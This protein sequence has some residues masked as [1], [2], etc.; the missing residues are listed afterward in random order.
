MLTILLIED[1]EGDAF[2]LRRAFD[3]EGIL[4]SIQVATDGK[5]GMRYLQ[6]EGEFHD[7][8][9][10]PFPDFVFTDLNMPV[11]NGFDLLEWR[12]T[13]ND[14]SVVP[15]MV[16]SASNHQQDIEKS[17][18]LGTNAYFVKPSSLSQLQK[19]LRDTHSFWMSTERPKLNK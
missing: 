3:R 15:V 17:Y 8:T 6:G 19:L 9:K 7:R 1:D 11:L 16:L 2:M 10:Y 4:G 12:K 14:F 5:Q 13:H 18:R